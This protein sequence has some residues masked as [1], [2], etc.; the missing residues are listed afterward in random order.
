MRDR[1][2]SFLPAIEGL[3]HVI[4]TQKNAWIHLFFTIVITAA[5][6]ILQISRLEFAII[7]LTM[8]FVWAAECFNTAIEAAVDLCSPQNHPLAKISKDTGAA[9]V[10]V[11]AVT[12][13][14]IGILI[15]A[16]PLFNFISGIF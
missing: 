13:V 8:G 1:I 10:L 3:F 11:A 15:L 7:F 6:L 2:R 12:S 9:A 14:I 4:K 16:P 5:G